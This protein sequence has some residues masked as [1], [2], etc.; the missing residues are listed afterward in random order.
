M[1]SPALNWILCRKL[2]SPIHLL[3]ETCHTL[4]ISATA[5]R[6]CQVFNICIEWGPLPLFIFDSN[7]IFFLIYWKPRKDEFL[8]FIFADFGVNLILVTPLWTD[9]GRVD[10][11][12][13]SFLQ[14]PLRHTF[15]FLS[16][17]ISR[18]AVVAITKSYARLPWGA[19]RVRLMSIGLSLCWYGTHF[20]NTVCSIFASLDGWCHCAGS[21]PPIVPSSNNEWGK[22]R[23]VS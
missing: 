2:F 8:V 18:C 12:S 16:S 5:V 6:I 4:I 22:L 7:S 1:K 9:P 17:S 14:S 23:L 19:I 13:K 3:C 20:L 15:S 21:F 11:K 10:A